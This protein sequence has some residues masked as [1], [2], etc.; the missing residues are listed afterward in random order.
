MEKLMEIK[1]LKV[2]NFGCIKDL[3]MKLTPLHAV[4]GPNDSGKSTL[5]RAVRTGM[6]LYAGHFNPADKAPSGGALISP[7]DPGSHDNAK[8]S[9]ALNLNRFNNAQYG[10]KYDLNLLGTQQISERL[11]P[12]NGEEINAKRS[13]NQV[14]Q[15]RY[16]YENNIHKQQDFFKEYYSKNCPDIK[17]ALPKM[18]RLDP[19]SLRIPGGHIVSAGAIDFE[20]KG[21]GLASVLDSLMKRKLKDYLKIREKIGGLF[22]TVE[23]IILENINDKQI[24]LSVKLKNGS[25]VASAFMS[26]GMLYYLA[27]S[28]LQYLEPASILLIEEPENGLHPSRIKE[29][30]TIIRE[31]SKTT[32]VL[33]ATHSPLVINE[34]EPEEVSIL[35]RDDEKGTQVMPMNKTT[36]FEQ[37]A[38][39]YALGELWLSYADG[40]TEKK[41]TGDK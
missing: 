37:R 39:V 24:M 38:K 1:S 31:L 17:L 7:F 10:F 34:M 30:M 9:I 23:D 4:I 40:E 21:Y 3:E 2:Q 26:E 5:L 13:W 14:T 8:I 41:L 35:W 36:N 25:Q 15:M 12:K 32:Q 18:V 27:Y 28:T 22:P 16:W 19:D 6:Q 29:I 20:E 11:K 33:I